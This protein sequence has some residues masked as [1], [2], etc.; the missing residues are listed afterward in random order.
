M[1]LSLLLILIFLKCASPFLLPTSSSP[2]ALLHS[3]EPTLSSTLT[4]IAS[5]PLPSTLSSTSATSFLQSLP[6]AA[7]LPVQP[8]QALP[9]PTGVTITFL[10]KGGSTGGL[11]LNVSDT[12][13]TATRDAANQPIPKI[14]S[15][16]IIVEQVRIRL[17]EATPPPPP[18]T[19]STS[20]PP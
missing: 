7:F 15:E 4:D 5:I 20:S 2:T 14:L 17:A 13:I 6:Y 9:T 19:S 12:A 1:S 16:N 11:I 8:L 18:P 3:Q 10:K